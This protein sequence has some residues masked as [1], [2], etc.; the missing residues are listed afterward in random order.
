M[1]NGLPPMSKLSPTF[2]GRP[3]S[4]RCWRAIFRLMT[5]F[6]WPLSSRLRNRPSPFSRSARGE[7]AE[8]R[9][10]G[11]VAQNNQ[12]LD[13]AQRIAYQ[14]PQAVREAEEPEDAEDRDRQAHQRQHRAQGTGQQVSPGEDTHQ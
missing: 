10:R 11:I 3:C 5:M 2:L 9:A 13:L 8:H 12:P 14:V 6:G 1:W 4:S 7:M